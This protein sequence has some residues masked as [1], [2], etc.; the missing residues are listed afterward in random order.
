MLGHLFGAR[1]HARYRSGA[2]KKAE[3][4]GKKQYRDGVWHLIEKGEKVGWRPPPGLPNPPLMYY[5]HYE[6]MDP[7]LDGWVHEADVTADTDPI[8]GLPVLTPPPLGGPAWPPA[9]SPQSG[10]NLPL[11]C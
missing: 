11:R 2:L 4:L 6:G 7:R 9:A 3:I 5:G 8:T 10:G 1:V